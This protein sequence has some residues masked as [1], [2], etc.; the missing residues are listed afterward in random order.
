[1]RMY[2]LKGKSLLALKQLKDLIAVN[3]DLVDKITGIKLNRKSLLT[4]SSGLDW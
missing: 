4:P 3:P 2:N 1:M